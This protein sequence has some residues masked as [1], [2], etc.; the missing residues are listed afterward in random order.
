M[1]LH[2][3]TKKMAERRELQKRK[4]F[5]NLIDACGHHLT[6]SVY[7]C[8]C[9]RNHYGIQAVSSI[10]ELAF[11]PVTSW[12]MCSVQHKCVYM[13]SDNCFLARKTS[14]LFS[15]VFSCS[16]PFFVSF[17]SFI[18]LLLSAGGQ[19]NEQSNGRRLTFLL[20]S[21]LIYYSCSLQYLYLYRTVYFDV[22]SVVLM[23]TRIL[24]MILNRHH[25]LLNDKQKKMEE[26]ERDRSV[27]TRAQEKKKCVSKKDAS[28]Y[29]I[30][31]Q[32]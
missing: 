7:I 4:T 29:N 22:Q 27:C 8:V 14:L 17:W 21:S 31:W 6:S 32:Q 10:L 1:C 28:F 9:Q 3:Q 12:L 15:Q 26:K 30:T 19:I 13:Y 18:F 20:L 16:L 11:L 5:H 23:M 24:S 2:R 25:Q